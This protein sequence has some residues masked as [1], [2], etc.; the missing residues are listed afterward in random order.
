MS[1]FP[2][3]ASI[4]T[5]RHYLEGQLCWFDGEPTHA[6]SENQ[7]QC[8]KCR[9]KW[10]YIQSTL[11]FQIFERFCNGERTSPVARDLGCSRN[12]VASHFRNFAEEVEDIVAEMIL[13]GTIA[14]NPQTIEEV[15]HLEK[16]LRVGSVKRR[17]RACLYLF[18][19][20]LDG[21]ERTEK[22]FART[23]GSFL[24]TRVNMARRTQ[25]F[26]ESTDRRG[27]GPLLR[28]V[29]A[30]AI[31][32]RPF[33]PKTKP[34]IETIGEHLVD[35]IARHFPS[36]PTVACCKLGKK[37]V[38]VWQACRKSVLKDYKKKK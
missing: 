11:E 15:I 2:P 13:E 22:L 19:H 24:E 9:F 38:D 29:A 32:L 8:S 6:S 37:W 14:T 31:H 36:R 18:L 16:A 17:R 25:T 35:W 4:A 23:I 10:S 33:K 26:M 21:V 27:S 28:N 30:P 1:E 34:L 5:Y 12:T 3:A 7:R 20:S